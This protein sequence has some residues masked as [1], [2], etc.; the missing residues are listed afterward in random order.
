MRE[1]IGTSIVITGVAP[2]EIEQR[3]EAAVSDPRRVADRSGG[4]RARGI[5]EI[6]TRQAAQRLVERG[7]GVLTDQV[8][9]ILGRRQRQAGGQVEITHRTVGRFNLDPLTANAVLH[10]GAGAGAGRR[11]SRVVVRGGREFRLILVAAVQIGFAAID[12]LDDEHGPVERVELEVLELLAEQGNVEGDAARGK[13]S[14]EFIGPDGFRI[15][16]QIARQRLR[17]AE[18]CKRS[19]RRLQRGLV[20]IEAARLVAARDAAI[21]QQVV[22][23]LVRQHAGAGEAMLLALAI[24]LNAVQ[25]GSVIGLAAEPNDGACCPAEC[26]AQAGQERRERGL[27]LDAGQVIIAELSIEPLALVGVA[28][29][30]RRIQAVGDVEDVVRED[31]EVAAVLLEQIAGA[32]AIIDTIEPVDRGIKGRRSGSKRRRTGGQTARRSRVV[33]CRKGTARDQATG[34]EPPVLGAE[35]ELIL[36]RQ[37]LVGVITA[38]QPVELL[39]ERRT[40]QP[41]FLGEGL[42]LAEAFAVVGAIEDVDRAVIEIAFLPRFVAAVAGDRRQLGAPEI[43]ADLARNS[44]VGG[45]GTETA[46]PRHGNVAA[47]GIVE[48]RQVLPKIAKHADDI[49]LRRIVEAADVAVDLVVDINRAAAFFDAMG[50]IADQADAEP[51]VGLVKQL[52]T[53]KVSVAVVDV[54]TVVPVVVEAVALDVDSVDPEG[55]A[56]GDRASEPGR[57]P[58]QVVIADRRFA[59]TAEGKRRLL[60]KD[61]DQ[62][63]RSV[64]T[65][66]RPLRSAQDLDPVDLAQFGE[67]NAR[68]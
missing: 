33:K 4:N 35:A 20:Q 2:I 10:V 54:G 62:A 8:V 48:R 49:I 18:A 60:R 23:R 14:A 9:A 27:V 24:D 34:H 45:L 59:R 28:H 21:E 44:A 3:R 22:G 63:G 12:V 6:L 7:T 15:E 30:D 57:K 52:A 19:N 68:A 5:R 40:L 55:E 50:I 51:V 53:D 16:L 29:A 41:Q 65:E 61:A 25:F 58:A 11:G 46:S 47:V 13:F 56:V 38:D 32:A 36:K 67:S 66:Q 31:R 26:R 39:V 42:E 17:P 37:V 1:Q 64:A 43:I